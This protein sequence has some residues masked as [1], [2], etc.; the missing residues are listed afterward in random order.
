MQHPAPVPYI[1]RTQWSV[2][3]VRMTTENETG[4]HLIAE[5]GPDREQFPHLKFP[6]F[7]FDINKTV[8]RA[9]WG[10]LRIDGL[11]DGKVAITKRYSGLGADR[12]FV[13]VAD[14]TKLLAD[15]ADAV[16][17][18]LRV[19]DEFG[20]LRHFAADAIDLRLEGP[21]VLIGDAPFGLVGGTGAVWGRTTE[22]P[23]TI[24]LTGRHPYLGVAKVEIQT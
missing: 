19:N 16:R 24:V 8:T 21:G 1:L 12:Q 17:V 13:M 14:E 15:G 7:T 10:T 11:I 5:G 22:T 9:T 18:V 23:G 2:D 3:T 20:S 4:E 6:P